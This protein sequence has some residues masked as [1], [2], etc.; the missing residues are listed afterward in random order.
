MK[1]YVFDIDGTLTA[2]RKLMDEMFAE[3]FAN[4]C[5]ENITYLCTGSD[6]SKVVQQVPEEILRSV[7]GTFVCSA[8]AFWRPCLTE[9]TSY[10]ESFSPSRDLISDLNDLIKNS[11]FTEKV[12]GH[13]EERIGMVNFSIAGRATGREDIRP[14]Y[15]KWDKETNERI[16]AVRFLE[17]RHLDLDFNIGG[18][19]SIDIHPKGNDKSRS[20]RL[21]RTWHESED[22]KIYFFGDKLHQGGND[23]PIIKE[24]AAG[25]EAVCVKS[26]SDLEKILF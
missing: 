17:S 6:W 22:V 10:R 4:F 14:A 1:I 18:E 11:G 13:I 12:G 20:I 25:D 9:D 8:N 3:K 26:Y 5:N 7:Y 16:S 2:P 19:V 23:Y 21:I 15:V 24:L